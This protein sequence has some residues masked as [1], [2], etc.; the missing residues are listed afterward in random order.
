MKAQPI[1][2][3]RL[4]EILSEYIHP[5][6]WYD[7]NKIINDGI[8]YYRQSIMQDKPTKGRAK[9]FIDKEPSLT[10][11]YTEDI[12]AI[13]DSPTDSPML[14]VLRYATPTSKGSKTR[15]YENEIDLQA[16]FPHIVNFARIP[17][18]GRLY[19]EEH[20]DRLNFYIYKG[21][22]LNDGCLITDELKNYIDDHNLGDCVYVFSTDFTVGTKLGAKLLDMYNKNTETKARAK[23]M[24]W[25]YFQKQYIRYDKE[26]DCYVRDERYKSELL[27][28]AI[29]SHASYIM[30]KIRES[31]GIYDGC[32]VVDAYK[33][34]GDYDIDRIH[35]LF[36]N[37]FKDYHYR[38]YNY[39]KLPHIIYANFAPIKKR[40]HHAKKTT[41]S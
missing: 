25:G 14:H 18:D 17:I 10:Y 15:S 37:E 23:E 33:W 32:F 21:K 8:T 31:I 3:K 1:D 9:S 5:T 36:K 29:K 7:H 16:A 27:M 13:L 22:A 38:V 24:H 28:I 20:P 39:T 4:D 12:Y 6:E 26:Q 34:D 41:K 30:L 35:E 11:S 19:R 2:D 40:S